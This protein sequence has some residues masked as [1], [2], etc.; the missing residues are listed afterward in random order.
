MGISIDYVSDIIKGN[1]TNV[2]RIEQIINIV[3]I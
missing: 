3:E 1:R 2:E